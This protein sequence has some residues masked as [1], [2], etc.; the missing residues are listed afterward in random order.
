MT[1]SSLVPLSMS[2]SSPAPAPSAVALSSA[3][4]SL[5]VPRTAFSSS[6]RSSG[7][8][9]GMGGCFFFLSASSASFLFS[10]S[11]A[12]PFISTTKGARGVISTKK[13]EPSAAGPP[14]GSEGTMERFTA[15]APRLDVST[16]STIFP[17]SSRAS[18]VVSS[19]FCLSC[20]SSIS[21]GSSSS[22]TSNTSTSTLSSSQR[23]LRV[24]SWICILSLMTSSVSCL[25]VTVEKFLTLQ[26]QFT[27][28]QVVHFPLGGFGFSAIRA[29]VSRR[30]TSQRPRRRG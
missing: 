20:S 1:G 7:D 5:L 29:F 15:S 26:T 24:N 8:I 10:S 4:R 13:G 25:R 2:A 3:S 23:S 22:P 21:S 28:Q 9:W 11:S 17:P 14:R 30:C 18:S 6:L 12:F 19:L 27:L 16:T